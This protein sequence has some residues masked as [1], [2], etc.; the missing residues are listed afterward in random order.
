M[1]DT[2]SIPSLSFA[3]RQS[4]DRLKYQHDIYNQEFKER[5][6]LMFGHP[7]Y[8]PYPSYGIVS[9]VNPVSTLAGSGD[10]LAVSANATDPLLVDVNPG[11]AVNQNGHWIQL[12]SYVRQRPLGNPAIGIVNV[13]YLRYVV[14]SAVPEINDYYQEVIPYTT[15]PGGLE[16]PP[17]VNQTAED[18]AQVYVETLDVYLNYSIEIRRNFVPLATVTMQA[19]QD[20]ITSL[21]TT[22]LAI[23]HTQDSYSWNRPWFS[24]NDMAHR[25]LLGTGVQ[26]PTNAHAQSQNDLTVGAFTPFQ[27]QLDHGMIIADD[28]SMPKIP[29]FRCQVSIPY[30]SVKTDDASGTYT[31]FPSKKYVDLP[32]FPIRLGKVW[33]EDLP[34]N[35]HAGE[36]LAAL[37]VDE[38]N[39]VVFA[40]D[41]PPVNES[42]GMYYTRVLAC[43]PPAG[44]NEVT[45]STNNPT[46]SELIVAGGIGRVNLAST[47]LD[48]SDAQKYPMLYDIL[49]DQDG[50]LIKTPQVLYCCK[51]LSVIG[52]SDSF[53][54]SQYG[55]A[56]LMMG[57][58]DASGSG[59]M[60]I[61]VRAY[62]K[63]VNGTSIDHLFEFLGGSWTD[64]GPV[65]QSSINITSLQMSTPIFASVE[66]L[67]IES[68]VDPGTDAAIVVWAMLNPYSTYDKLKDACY[69]SRIMWDGLR[70]AK[71]W[72]R[73]IIGTTTRDFMGTSPN[74]L[75][76]Y[77]F[78]LMAGGN[79]SVYVDDM[80]C[81]KYRNLVPNE[82]ALLSNFF[83]SSPAN[84]L[85]KLQIG[86]SDLYATAGLPVMSGSGAVW[87]LTL[88]PSV[89]V[90]PN[91]NYGITLPDPTLFY[92]D[93]SW[94]SFT[95]SP[96]AGVPRTYEYTVP[97]GT[98]LRVA[99][100]FFAAETTGMVLYG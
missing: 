73:R 40:G 57:L 71:L 17:T 75:D 55:P 22:N 35:L 82:D 68:L 83:F 76:Q 63:D 18:T 24:A 92:Y 31:G 29:G 100:H 93:T 15:R 81:P 41:D 84:N 5:L 96:V 79:A 65:P 39:R 91:L 23:D 7:D 97:S 74:M 86:T 11:M 70:F 80:R 26:S 78:H 61:K 12:N 9:P 36:V 16:N 53:T 89:Q 67:A 88:F 98:P 33:V 34:A 4:M 49:V 25:A 87:R 52:T 1:A 32:N 64:P 45:F 14:S 60:E 46:S 21:V 28:Q 42:I 8:I 30:S 62:G 2:T 44:T 20:P 59:T 27:L 51:K 69:I 54:I 38:T 56:H 50:T 90:K 94:H 19:V 47:T 95:M 3:I 10:P 37:K 48:F 58:I 43:E 85:D 13:V 72:D 99:V 77:L 66:N 6:K